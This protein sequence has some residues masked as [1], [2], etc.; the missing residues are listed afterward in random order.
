MVT[1]VS[2]HKLFS[3][4]RQGAAV[5]GLD[6]GVQ[7]LQHLEQL[8]LFQ[9]GLFQGM[10]LMCAATMIPFGGALLVIVLQG[11][12]FAEW[13]LSIDA[14]HTRVSLGYLRYIGVSG[15]STGLVYVT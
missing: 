7:C 4:F 11:L 5:V 3:D 12:A 8:F 15:R 1:R 13:P 2:S 6:I 14:V 10:G 9:A